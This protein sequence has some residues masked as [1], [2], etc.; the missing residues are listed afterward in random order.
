M[1]E[2]GVKIKENKKQIGEAQRT[3]FFFLIT[4]KESSFHY[5]KFENI[6]SK[7][8]KSYAT[9]YWLND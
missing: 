3:F 6:S 8:P 2:Y 5:F 1:H 4:K 7:Q 9:T